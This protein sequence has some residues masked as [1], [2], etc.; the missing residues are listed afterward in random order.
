MDHPP[1]LLRLGLSGLGLTPL[2]Q[3]FRD[4][5][6]HGGT[7]GNERRRMAVEAETEEDQ[8]KMRPVA[9]I[10]EKL[11]HGFFIFRGR[12]GG[13]VFAVHPDHV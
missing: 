6:G 11:A 10:A 13:R 4:M 8:I 7:P 1:R 2:F 5:V 3:I 12:L 9:G